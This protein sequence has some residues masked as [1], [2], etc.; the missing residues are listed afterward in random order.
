M[1]RSGSAAYFTKGTLIHRPGGEAAN[2]G[3]CKTSIRG[4][5]SRPGLNREAISR[6][7]KRLSISHGVGAKRR[8]VR[9]ETCTE[10]V[11]F[12]SRPGLTQNNP[13]RGVILCGNLFYINPRSRQPRPL[14]YPLRP[15]RRQSLLARHP[16]HLHHRRSRHLHHHHRL[17]HPH[18]ILPLFCGERHW[19]V[20]LLLSQDPSPH[21]IPCRQGRPAP[22]QALP[23][24]QR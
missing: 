15:L 19:R 8:R 10:S 22:L 23:L 16:H 9:Y 18:H 6:E 4:F 20:L 7:S 12:D 17:L 3:V 2:T 11:R 24:H 21:D 1:G 14:P 13:A 5:D